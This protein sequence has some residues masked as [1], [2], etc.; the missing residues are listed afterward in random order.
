MRFL[1]V[2]VDRIRIGQVF[3]NRYLSSLSILR[4]CRSK[5]THPSL[6]YVC[7]VGRILAG[8]ILIKHDRN[9]PCVLLTHS[10]NFHFGGLHYPASLDGHINLTGYIQNVLRAC[11]CVSAPEGDIKITSYFVLY[12][13]IK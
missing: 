4:F 13:L 3:C 2:R 7:Y 8:S 9:N 6:R 11:E 5:S 12:I 1:N 10:L